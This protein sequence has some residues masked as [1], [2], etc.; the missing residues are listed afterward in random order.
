MA[1][2]ETYRHKGMRAGRQ[3]DRHVD[4]QRERKTDRQKERRT[5]RHRQMDVAVRQEY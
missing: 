4:T 3:I 2:S 1:C 5:D